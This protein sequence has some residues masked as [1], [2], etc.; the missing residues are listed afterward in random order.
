MHTRNRNQVVQVGV[1][2]PCEYQRE[3]TTCTHT[4]ST[5]LQSRAR[6][7]CKAWKVLSIAWSLQQ[8]TCSSSAS[9]VNFT[10]LRIACLCQFLLCRD[11]LAV[12]AAWFRAAGKAEQEAQQGVPP[13]NGHSRESSSNGDG[14]LPQQS[15]SLGPL[16][17]FFIWNVRYTSSLL[18]IL[19]RILNGRG[20]TVVCGNQR[21]SATTAPL[22]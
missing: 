3:S 1:V 7:L 21:P 10:C 8:H 17:G 16:Y 5:A 20:L 12:S 4:S 6:Q 22:H 18:L 19:Y 9:L 15:R 2:S 13:T 11:L 14:S